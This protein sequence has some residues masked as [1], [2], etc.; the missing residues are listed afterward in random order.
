MFQ[1]EHTTPGRYWGEALGLAFVADLMLMALVAGAFF[2]GRWVV[3][4]FRA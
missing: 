1:H 2:V 3:R 4:G